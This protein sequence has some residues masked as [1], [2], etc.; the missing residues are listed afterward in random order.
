MIYSIAYSIGFYKIF[1]YIR[2]GP[3]CQFPMHQSNN[4]PLIQFGH[5]K[6]QGTWRRNGYKREMVLKGQNLQEATWAVKAEKTLLPVTCRII[7]LGQYIL[8]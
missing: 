3:Y 4:I 8:L 5:M 6:F 2:A 1:L 7:F